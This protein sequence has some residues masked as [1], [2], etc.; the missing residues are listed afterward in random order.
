MDNTL[1][2]IDLHT[3]TTASDGDQS[4]ID[5][6]TL[7]SNGGLTAIAITDHDTTAGISPD[8]V[9]LGGQLG[10]E[11][12]AGIELSV[13][14]SGGQLHLLGYFIDPSS[15]ILLTRLTLLQDNRIRRNERIVEKLRD[16]GID[17]TLNEIRAAAGGDVVGRPHFAKVLIQKGVVSTMQE[18]FDKYI[19]DGALAHVPKDKLT[20]TEAINLIHAAGGKAVLAHPNNLKR[21]PAETEQEILR[22]KEYGLDGIEARYSRHTPEDTSRYLD[23]AAR[24]ALLTSGGSDFHGPTVKPTVF[25]GHVENDRPAPTNL[26]DAL[27]A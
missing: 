1:R 24:L 26:L 5:L 11:V 12:I 6:V 4:P 10:V 21:S 22:L 18:A 13:E 20:P 2:T 3:H 27:R 25:L 17:I 19:A 9:A 8:A 7:A 16:L 23:M 14:F 15:P